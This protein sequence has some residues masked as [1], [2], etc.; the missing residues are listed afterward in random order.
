MKL[1]IIEIKYILFVILYI[2]L[3]FYKLKNIYD[4]SFWVQ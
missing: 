3:K 2:L 4:P 1:K